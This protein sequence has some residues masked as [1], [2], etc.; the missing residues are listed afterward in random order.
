MIQ[1]VNGNWEC[2]HDQW[3]NQTSWEL[4]PC[5]PRSP[6]IIFCIGFVERY[7]SLHSME[8]CFRWI[9]GNCV[10][11]FFV[12]T[13]SLS[14]SDLH[15]Q[16]DYCSAA[17]T[18]THITTNVNDRCGRKARKHELIFYVDLKFC[19]FQLSSPHHCWY[20]SPQTKSGPTAKSKLWPTTDDFTIPFS[21]P[22]S[23]N[24][25]STRQSLPINNSRV[26][27]HFKRKED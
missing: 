18:V 13:Q 24:F 9:I 16:L 23:G 11:V 1:L 10:K 14:P 15:P 12:W 20:L 2:G 5:F 25:L 19:L 21:H 3:R 17:I 26:L 27:F 22:L 8:L 4:R 6:Q 7:L